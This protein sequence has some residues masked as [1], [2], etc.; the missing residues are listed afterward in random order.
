MGWSPFRR[1]G[2]TYEDSRSF[3]GYTLI[4]PIGGDAVYLLDA[5][6]ERLQ[7]VHID[8]D[9]LHARIVM[10]VFRHGVCPLPFKTH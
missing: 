7:A 3:G 4:T 10:D 5:L 8:G 9:I 1:T 6:Q 2:L